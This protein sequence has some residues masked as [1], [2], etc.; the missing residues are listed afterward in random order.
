ML[1]IQETST[2]SG[3]PYHRLSQ[4]YCCQAAL[5]DCDAVNIS[6]DRIVLA[7]LVHAAH[8]RMNE[9]AAHQEM[10]DVSKSLGTAS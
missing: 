6:H 5:G 4:G 1:R 8:H 10:Y 9:R 3:A 7:R 2:A